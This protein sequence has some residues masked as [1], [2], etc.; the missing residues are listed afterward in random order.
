[1]VFSGCALMVVNIILYFFFMQ[2][3][4]ALKSIKHKE[5]LLYFPFLLLIFFLLGYLLVGILGNPSII[6][7][8]IL[9]GGA[10]YVFVLILAL[11]SIIKKILEDDKFI[12]LRYDDMRSNYN[13]LVLDSNFVVYVNLTEDLIVE[14]AGKYLQD[15]AVTSYSQFIRSL[16][17]SLIE[18]HK[19]GEKRSFTLSGLLSAFE[20]GHDSV[21]EIVLI[22]REGIPTFVK[23]E[24]QMVKQPETGNILAFIREKDYNHE[25]VNEQIINN[26]LEQQYD[27]IAY[28]R[29]TVYEVLVSSQNE[30]CLPVKG[31]N[32]LN[33]F[34]DNILSPRLEYKEQLEEFKAEKI[35]DEVSKNNAYEIVLVLNVNG[36]RYKKFSFYSI[37][38]QSKIFI[39]MVSDITKEHQ[40]QASMNER[41]S[42]ALE[43]TRKATAA[44]SMF[45]S[46]MSHDIRT[47]M[48]AI[49][50]FV[51]LSKLT[52]DPLIIRDYLNKIETASKH[53]LS[54]INDILVMSRLESGKMSLLP[55]PCDLEE[56][57]DEM[58]DIFAQQMKGK[59]LSYTVEKKIVHRYLL[60]DK[61]RFHRVLINLINNAYKFT[62]SGEVRV[63]VEELS[64][65]KDKATYVFS[66][67]DTGVGMSEEFAQKI[68][69]AFERERTMDANNVQGTGLGMAITKSIVELMGGKIELNTALGKGSEFKVIVTFDLLDH[70]LYDN[71]AEKEALNYHCVKGLKAVLADDNEVNREIASMLL[72]S[73]GIEI[74]EAIDGLDAYEKI[75]DSVDIL[76][77]DIQMPVMNGYQ[78]AQKIRKES[79]FKNLPII[80][81]TADAFK[82]DIDKALSSGIDDVVTKPINFD[83]LIEKII[84][85]IEKH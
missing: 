24:A 38:K 27:L 42:L 6:V 79:S 44:K 71:K 31:N 39:L 50:G 84:K 40:E 60:L 3:I 80:A 82:E 51:E 61:N 37:N 62:S 22:E 54:L 8:S 52:D 7:S 48:N 35:I 47:P 15:S 83:E 21:S 55:A 10:I 72:K 26:V 34:I 18:R 25:T 33:D 2:K 20:E 46:N 69:N 57:M 23:L 56:V 65:E 63:A 17:M 4:R 9:F 64:A 28:F 45:F 41:L 75:D 16:G 36:V 53:L 13:R 68:Y 58:Y 67:K 32:N 73:K 1:M 19:E 5:I 70:A 76:L 59:G 11:N 85:Q 12:K 30:F 66:V 14:K 78:L 74:V 77:T 29:G 81:L 49:I 43:D